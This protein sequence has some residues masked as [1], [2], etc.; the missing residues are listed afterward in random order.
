MDLNK[1]KKKKRF[2]IKKE[3][4]TSRDYDKLSLGIERYVKFSEIIN[5]WKRATYIFIITTFLFLTLSLVAIKKSKIIPYVVRMD[6]T[7]GAVVDTKLLKTNG[8][9]LNQKEIEY[10]VRKFYTSI[11]TITLDKNVFNQTISDVSAFLTP[12]SQEKLNEMIK[13]NNVEDSFEN[14]ITKNIEIISYNAIPNITNT[15]QVRFFENEFDNTGKLKSK[16]L[17]NSIIKIDFFTPSEKE[18]LKNPL[19]IAIV[20]FTISKENNGDIQ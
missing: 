9:N 3:D 16:S 18:V 4:T 6:T 8:I 14:G 5:L 11:R 17:Y 15:Y 12:S 1:L 20:D 13:Q 10:F 2:F 7:T 19:G